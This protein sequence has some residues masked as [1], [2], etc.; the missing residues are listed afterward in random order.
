MKTKCPQEEQ[1]FHF[2]EGGLER[3]VREELRLHLN[4]CPAC[5]RMVASFVAEEPLFPEEELLPEAFWSHYDTKFEKQ[6]SE[7]ME[8]EI[9]L[10]SKLLQYWRTPISVPLPVAATAA[11]LIVF[12]SLANLSAPLRTVADNEKEVVDQ[13]L[14]EDVDA[15]AFYPLEYY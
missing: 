2:V 12:L 9:S 7:E 3:E 14:I 11:V 8:E 10:W 13:V 5:C 6:L 1:L 4:E 15:A